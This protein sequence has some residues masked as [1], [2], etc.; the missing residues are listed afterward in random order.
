MPAPDIRADWPEIVINGR[1]LSQRVTGVQR[2]A[3]ETIHALDEL[4][5]ER[6]DRKSVV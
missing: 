2:Y 1:F 5:A 4:L 3:R 6:A